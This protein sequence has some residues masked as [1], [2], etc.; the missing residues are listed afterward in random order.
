MPSE[1][2]VHAATNVLVAG[3]DS[4][5][6]RVLAG[7]CRRPRHSRCSPAMRGLGFP[8]SPAAGP[9]PAA[10]R[11]GAGTRTHQPERCWRALVA[12]IH[13]VFGHGANALIEPLVV[14][15]DVHDTLEYRD[16]DDA[17]AERQVVK[18]ATRL[19]RRRRG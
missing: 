8:A 17:D 18:V 1:A 12:R 13:R 19:L 10:S 4:R 14:L 3:L 7:P 11:P 9:R 2:I 6:L 5:S 15:D 16:E